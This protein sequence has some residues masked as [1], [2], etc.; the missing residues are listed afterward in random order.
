MFTFSQKVTFSL[1]V[2]RKIFPEVLTPDVH[3]PKAVF[4]QMKISDP[5]APLAFHFIL[6]SL[7]YEEK[8]PCSGHGLFIQLLFLR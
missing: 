2:N 8:R 1:N 3:D 4:A 6:R 7:P 5:A